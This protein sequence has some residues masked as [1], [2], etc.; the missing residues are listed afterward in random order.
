MRRGLSFDNSPALSV[1]LRFFLNAPVFAMLA[2]VL[3]LWAGPQA[4]ASRW[5]L[6]TLALTHLLTLGV[7]AS[8]MIGALMQILPV[9]T[10]ISVLAPRLTACIVHACLTLGTL[11]LAAAFLLARPRLFEAA[12]GLLA[13]AF[14]WLLS[15]WAV[16]FRRHRKS[17]PNDT[18]EVLLATCLALAA[19]LAAILLGGLLAA[20]FAWSLAIP[21]PRL[22][23]IHAAWG[24]LG[25][26]GLLVIGISYQVIPIFQATEL[27]PRIVTCWL[28]P[29]IF[30]VLALWTA[31]VLLLS[32][33]DHI[34]LRAITALLGAAY[35]AFAGTTFYLLWIRKRPKADAT[36]LFWR[37]AMISMASCVPVW[38]AQIAT[39]SDY[40]ILL[41]V[42]SIVGFAWS[43]INGMLYKILPF[44]LWYH[45]QSNVT[46]ASR[47]VPK[48]KDIIPDTIAAK[49]FKAHLPAL[50]LLVA[51]SIQPP[52]FTHAAGIAFTISAAWLGWNMASALRLYLNA[53][54]AISNDLKQARQKHAAPR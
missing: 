39:G 45:A 24:L 9:A 33:T 48:V 16:G 41:G 27:Y 3:L 2:G 43:A 34:A 25:W 29:L 15:A 4:L 46:I 40:S 20:G 44:L 26:V 11:V 1:P 19:L 22:T 37:T 6:A 31:G 14:S 10:G 53:R 32:A 7:L 5:T 12:L 23:D 35:L 8:V 54:N 49:Q 52:L 51:A 38:L 36:T 47:L 42:L 30:I 18:K 28:A 17:M 50:L 21:M 13:I